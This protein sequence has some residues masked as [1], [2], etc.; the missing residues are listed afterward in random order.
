MAGMADVAADCIQLSAS[1]ILVMS[2]GKM[3]SL[4]RKCAPPHSSFVMQT[5]FI[6]EGAQD[7]DRLAA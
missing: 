7:V 5:S 3:C 4:I 2:L 6:V 1:G